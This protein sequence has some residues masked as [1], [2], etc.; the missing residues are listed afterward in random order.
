MGQDR[1]K[2]AVHSDLAASYRKELYIFFE[3]RSKLQ[4][5]AK[6]T[7][8]EISGDTQNFV[9]AVSKGIVKQNYMLENGTELITMILSPGDL[10]GEV[11][12]LH[13]D[14]NPISSIAHTDVELMQITSSDFAAVLQESPDVYKYLS[15]LLARKVRILLALVCDTSFNRVEV[16]LT[17]ILERLALQCGEV[18]ADGVKISVIFTHQDLANMIS[19]TRSTVT[20]QLKVMVKNGD[21]AVEGRHIIL[22][23]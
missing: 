14:I 10:F 11:T 8:I 18:V 19:T 17:N 3:K 9:Y 5:F 20:K 4:R 7:I 13:G 2:N 12:Y 15:Y 6:N 21:I 22:K 1:V 23:R 16:R